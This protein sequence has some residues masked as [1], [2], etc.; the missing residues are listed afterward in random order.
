VPA[1]W[2]APWPEALS[3]GQLFKAADIAVSDIRTPNLD[4]IRAF[5][6][7]IV[8]HTSNLDCIKGA[9]F[10]VLAVKP[11]LVE[12]IAH[13]I[14]DASISTNKSSSPSPPV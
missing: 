14:A 12:L 2:A 5:N 9:D 1:I 4:A 11:W 8:C 3:Q 13:E 10:I 7:T 6:P